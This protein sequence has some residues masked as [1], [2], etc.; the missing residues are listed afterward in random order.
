M[1][2]FVRKEL[3]MKIVSVLLTL[4]ILL[5]ILPPVTVSVRAADDEMITFS[6]GAVILNSSYS[7]KTV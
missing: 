5:G 6:T 7:G 2:R 1:H 3:N 4:A